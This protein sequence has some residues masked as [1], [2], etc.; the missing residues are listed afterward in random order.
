[1]Q[2]IADEIHAKQ[3]VRK[4][5][6]WISLVDSG[7]RTGRSAMAR[8]STPRSDGGQRPAGRDLPASCSAYRGLR[9]PVT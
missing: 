5:D 6:I 9:R 2:H 1:M 8:C 4:Q 3:G 7:V